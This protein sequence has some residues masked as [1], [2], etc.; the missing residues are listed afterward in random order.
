MQLKITI[1]RITEE[2]WTFKNKKMF[3][4]HG[5]ILIKAN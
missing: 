5:N 2:L 4:S 1:P 3:S